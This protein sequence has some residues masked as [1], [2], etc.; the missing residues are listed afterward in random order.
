MQPVDWYN[1]DREDFG[2]VWA[3]D[4]LQTLP[5]STETFDYVVMNHSLQAFGFHDI[6]VVLKE[7]HRVT[8]E[9]GVIRILVPD[10]LEGF[11]AAERGDSGWFP[12]AAGF[13]EV[14]RVDPGQT[15]CE[16]PH[17]CDLDNRA[18]ETFIMEGR[19][20]SV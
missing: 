13:H 8:K 19:C 10:V 16:D 15:I 7:L 9:D 3:F 14:T 17:I 11:R 6:P 2:Q 12:V 4:L 20:A 5:F 1:L 18:G